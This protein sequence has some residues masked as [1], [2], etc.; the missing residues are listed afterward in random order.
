MIIDF[1]LKIFLLTILIF[2]SSYFLGIIVYILFD[3]FDENLEDTT[4]ETFITYFSLEGKS[5]ASLF[6]RILFTQDSVNPFLPS[7]DS[8]NQRF[9]NKTTTCPNTN[10]TLNP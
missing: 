1:L 8:K 9:T 6:K 2:N 10:T 3:V 4:G 7:W 5:W